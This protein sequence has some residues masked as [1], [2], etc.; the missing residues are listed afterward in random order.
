MQ[1]VD[2]EIKRLLGKIFNL[3]ESAEYKVTYFTDYETLFLFCLIAL[4]LSVIIFFLSY[5]LGTGVSIL[6]S[7]MLSAYECGFDPFLDSRQIIDIK[8]H[9]IAI[10]FVIFD[11]EIALFIPW[12]IV[13]TNL[14]GFTSWI[15]INVILFLFILVIGLFFEYKNKIF[16]F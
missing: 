12:A 2:Q 3:P 16:D 14:I 15:Y 5:T 10:L 9:I 11:I 4:L 1:N 7:S 6:D 8:F 13:F